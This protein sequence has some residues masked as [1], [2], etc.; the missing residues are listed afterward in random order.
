[1]TRLSI[2]LSVPPP[3]AKSKAAQITELLPEIEAALS[4][5]NSHDA[6]FENVK[7]TIGLELTFGYYKN[8]LHRARH[9]QTENAKAKSKPVSPPGPKS[10][11]TTVSPKSTRSIDAPTSKLQAK[12]GEGVGDFFS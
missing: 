7:K 8:T 2:S 6:I 3:K 10:L 11:P 1:M 5:G 12:L 9:R 4:A